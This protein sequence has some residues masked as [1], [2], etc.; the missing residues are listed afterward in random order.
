MSKSKYADPSAVQTPKHPSQ[1]QIRFLRLAMRVA[2]M[3][4][5]RHRH[6]CVIVHKGEVVAMGWNHMEEHLKDSWSFHAEMDAL[7]K[8]N[9]HKVRLSECELYVVRLGK[10]S[11]GN[12]FKNSCPCSRCAEAIISAGI[13]RAYFSC[14]GTLEEY[15]KRDALVRVPHVTTRVAM[16]S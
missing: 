3:S 14:E 1:D 15:E 10:E 12:Q 8:V 11:M 16:R 13:K 5:M 7:F 9:K 6:G 4:D 2:K